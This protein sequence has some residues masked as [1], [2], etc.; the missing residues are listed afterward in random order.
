MLQ[1]RPVAPSTYPHRSSAIAASSPFLILR[2]PH[3]LLA[4]DMCGVLAEQQGDKPVGQVS[5]NAIHFVTARE[6]PPE[7]NVEARRSASNANVV[8]AQYSEPP[9]KGLQT[10]AEAQVVGQT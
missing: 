8:A 9:N 4:P 10:A 1:M 3:P 5:F 2:L 6:C 7:A